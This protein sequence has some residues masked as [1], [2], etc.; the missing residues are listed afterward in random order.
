MSPL[1]AL[2]V[3]PAAYVLGSVSPAYWFGRLLRGI[4]LRE[5]GSGNLGARNAGRILGRHVGV[6]VWLL[7]MAKGAVA[8]AIAAKAAGSIGLAVAAGAAAVAGHNWPL[9]HGLRGGRGASTAMGAVFALLP[10]QMA[11]GLALWT[12]I[13]MVSGSLYLGGLVA[14]PTTALLA[15]GTGVRGMR[16][17]SPLLI[18]V[19][20][21][22][23]H[24]PA[25]VSQIR[26]RELRLP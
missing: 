4:D 15:L 14:Y 8:V 16:A 3:A 21:M 13:S 25:L 1:I 18:T 19:P 20:L 23:R 26:R 7:D 9:F 11:A 22:L 5:V 6:T 17:F 12:G 10:A 24:I 2:A